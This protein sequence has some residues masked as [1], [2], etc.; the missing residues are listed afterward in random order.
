VVAS[1]L[2]PA[3]FYY[4]Y[5]AFLTPFL[6]LVIALPVSRLLAALPPG[7]TRRW[8]AALRPAAMVTAAT[9]IVVLVV[10]QVIAESHEYSG[11]PSNEISA[12]DR[13]IPP[14][15]CVATDQASYTIAIDRFVS[16]V[17]GCSLMIDGVGTDYALSNGRNGQTGAGSSPAVEAAWMS[18]FRTAKYAWLTSEAYRRISWTP[19]LTA[20]FDSH[21]VS[22]MTAG[23]DRLFVRAAHPEPGRLNGIPAAPPMPSTHY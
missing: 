20:Y 22:L 18:A 15:A 5:A 2:W 12:A 1:F 10:L 13:L 21:F 6:A 3:D 4:H 14:G 11:V 7:S 19:Q 8:L 23:R 17:P 9:A 16:S